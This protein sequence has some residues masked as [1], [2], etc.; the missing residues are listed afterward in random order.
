MNEPFAISL[1]RNLPSAHP[2][3]RLLQPHFEGIIGINAQARQHLIA[4]SNNAFARFMSA[5][6]NLLP[7][8]KN[9]CKGMHYDHMVMP[10]HFEK[11][12]LLDIPNFYFRDDCMSMWSILL[13]Y[14]G[15]MVDLSYESD[16]WVSNDEELQLFVKEI[17]GRSA[18]LCSS[19]STES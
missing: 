6:D 1:H 18:F 9:C 13:R 3:Y 10:D 11:R 7:L 4:A 17:C 12:G 8:L 5:G 14:V 2:L 19:S 16:D 15:E